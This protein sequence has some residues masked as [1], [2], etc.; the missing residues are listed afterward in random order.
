M[1]LLLLSS[2]RVADSGYLEASLS[3][4][5]DVL[6]DV[7]RPA[8]FV[9]FAGVTI[10]YDA[11]FEMVKEAL[12]S[13]AVELLPLHKM[14]DAKSAITGAGAIIVGGGNTFAL[15]HR[16]QSQEL[17]QPIRDAVLS[18]TPYIGWSAGSNIAAPTICTTNDMPIVE[19]ASFNAL[20]LVPYQINPHYT[21]ATIP[22]HNGESRRQRLMEYLQLNPAQQVVCLPEGTYLKI[23]E[24]RASFNG[25]CCGLLLRHSEEAVSIA[26]GEE[27]PL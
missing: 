19:P 9:P 24:K 4:I 26:P 17:L 5:G 12:S 8:V 6:A 7:T 14:A 10:D 27:L 3:T 2:S 18:G 22:G 23:D 25:K 21:E 20:S 1:Q 13:I 16:L 11:Y 15:L